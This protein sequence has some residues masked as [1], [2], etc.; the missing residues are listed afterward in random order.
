MGGLEKGKRERLGWGG[1]GKPKPSLW[2]VSPRPAQPL[3]PTAPQWGA[4]EGPGRPS[5]KSLRGRNRTKSR[6]EKAEVSAGRGWRHLLPRYASGLSTTPPLIWALGPESRVGRAVGARRG[7]PEA[8]C[9]PGGDWPG[10]GPLLQ[11]LGEA[12]RPPTCWPDALLHPGG[13]TLR[14]IQ[15][16]LSRA[17]GSVPHVPPAP[18]DRLPSPSAAP[19]GQASSKHQQGG[20][21]RRRSLPTC[22]PEYKDFLADKEGRTRGGERGGREPGNGE[23]GARFRAERSAGL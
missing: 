13:L 19:R 6:A 2:Q 14:V 1:P 18:P 9:L 12:S 4:R 5:E 21:A 8:L 3:P 15:G 17:A 11:L 10:E 7:T 20:D 16:S 23:R 22:N